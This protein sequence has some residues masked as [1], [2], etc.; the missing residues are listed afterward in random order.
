ME[1]YTGAQPHSILT[2]SKI[3]QPKRPQELGQNLNSRL[4]ITI[5]FK[6]KTVLLFK[7]DFLIYCLFLV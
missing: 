5:V 2:V 3:H 4:C 1:A 7:I 6:Y